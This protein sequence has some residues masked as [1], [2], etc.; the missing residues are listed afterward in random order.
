MSLPRYPKYK[1]SGVEWMGSVPAHW[2]VLPI[3]R[4]ATLKSGDSINSDAIEEEGEYPVFGGNGLRGYT[5]AY[6]HDGIFP[7]IG[8]QGALCGNINYGRGKFWASEHAVVAA[9]NTDADPLWL[10]ET[11]RAMNLNQYSV[12]AAQPG[13]SVEALATLRIPVPS[14]KE[15]A[16]IAAFLDRETAK[17]DALVAEQERLI[18]LLKE[19]CQAMISHAV[20][21][22]LNPKAPMK[23][24]GVEWLGNMPTHWETCPLKY[25]ARIGNGSTPNRDNPEYWSEDGFP[26]LNS[27]VVNMDQVTEAARFITPLALKECHLPIVDPPAVLVGITGQGKTRGM[28]A[29]LLFTATVNQ[30]LAYIKPDESRLVVSYLL[31]VLEAAYDHL[32]VESE[33]VGSTKGAITCAQLASLQIPMPPIEDQ[34]SVSEYLE[35]EHGRLSNLES[36]AE[37]AITLLKERRAA[38]ISAAVTGQID[39]RNAA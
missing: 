11:L 34:V 29:P 20:T 26:W 39:V 19:K 18:A 3:R 5:G 7:L 2:N 16:A 15:Q 10:G 22:G 31:D 25:V 38:L 9:L 23:P 14:R 17:I 8:R 21:K 28:A 36:E 27:S 33:G 6:T 32:R 35:Q 13:L 12:S 24:S 37:R 4:V 1:P 30:H